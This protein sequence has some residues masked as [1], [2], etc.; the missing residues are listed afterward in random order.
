MIEICAVGGYN[1]V[2]KNCTAVKIDNEIV[3]LDLGLHLENYI[4]FTED[5]EDLI[6]IS[7]KQLMKVGAV[8][9]IEHIN[10]WKDEVKAIVIGHG[11]LDHVGAVPYLAD[12]FKAPIICAPYTKAII[13]ITLKDEK[14]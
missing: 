2:G 5:R 10:D 9:N 1:E 12:S 4:K 13:D 14:I 11:H 3:I 7:G 6:D 8:P